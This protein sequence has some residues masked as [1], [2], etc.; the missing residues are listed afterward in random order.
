MQWP[1]KAW[2]NSYVEWHQV[3]IWRHGM[4]LPVLPKERCNSSF[5]TTGQSISAVM[6]MFRKSSHSHTVCRSQKPKIRAAF[7]SGNEAI[8]WPVYMHLVSF[9]DQGSCS[10]T[11]LYVLH[12]VPKLVCLPVYVF[13][14]LFASPYFTSPHP[15]SPFFQ[16]SGLGM[17]SVWDC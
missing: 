8:F 9:P 17:S 6:V 15:T 7:L 12:S 13:G 16:V 5:I 2:W 10:Q 1:W 3:D 14:S 11:S 4:A